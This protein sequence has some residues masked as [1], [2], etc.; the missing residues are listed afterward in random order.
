MRVCIL[1]TALVLSLSDLFS[2][3]HETM[4][5]KEGKKTSNLVF[6]LIGSNV[7]LI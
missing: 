7:L 1:Y 5:I 4:E 3:E 2:M 6:V